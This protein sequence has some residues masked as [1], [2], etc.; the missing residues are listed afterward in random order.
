MSKP[1]MDRRHLLLGA[2]GLALSAC[3]SGFSTSMHGRDLGM[4]AGQ[5]SLERLEAD[6]GG[7]LGVAAVNFATGNTLEHRAD[8][9]FAMCSTFKCVLGALVLQ[10]VEREQE[11]LSRLIYYVESDLVYYSP[12]TKKSAG[13][14]MTVDAL[15][16]AMLTTSDNTAANLLLQTLGGP[17]GFTAGVRQWG[18]KIT[19]LDRFETDLNENVPDDPRDTT[20]PAA[21][22]TLLKDLLFGTTLADAS[23]QKLGNWMIDNQTGK[24]KLRAGF[25][26]E[27]LVGNR[28]GTSENNQSNDLCFAIDESVQGGATGPLIIVSYSNAPRPM[29]VEANALHANVAREVLRALT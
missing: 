22:V 12:V 10:R 8:E 21:M 16:H 1:T 18:D 17:E 19:R 26:P 29:S 11:S 24:S 7:R 25:G 3:T 15:C 27:W 14:G 5:V 2:G 28:T 6:S 4:R 23:R 9:R 13:V 20:T